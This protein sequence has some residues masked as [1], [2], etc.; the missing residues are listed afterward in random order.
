MSLAPGRDTPELFSGRK[1][2][3]WR[4]AKKHIAQPGLKPGTEKLAGA[5]LGAA[6]AGI[7]LD[8]VEAGAAVVLVDDLLAFA[9]GE[10]VVGSLP[11]EAAG[12]GEQDK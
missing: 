11:V 4:E 6:T 8:L 2:G 10:A 3:L 5:F 7:L 1:A 9:A 12:K